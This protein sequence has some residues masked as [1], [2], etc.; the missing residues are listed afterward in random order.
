MLIH[1]WDAADPDEWRALLLDGHDFGQL[2]AAGRGRDVP[3]V[4]PTHFHYDGD[5]TV[6][7]HLARPN[8][9]WAAIEE[10][11][12]VL[13]T[14]IA[15]YAYVPGTWKADEGAD[16]RTGIPTSYYASVQLTA[17]ASVVDDP[18]G[19]R[20]ILRAS[21]AHFSPDGDHAPV[22][23]GAAWVDRRLPA[24]R[25]LRLAVTE[26]RAKLKYG[27]NMPARRRLDIAERLADRD[28]PNDAAARAHLL[29]RL[30]R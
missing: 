15:D 18:E 16:P 24:I 19:K 7:L 23:E 1:P 30:D 3:V 10:N 12:T 20:K 25:G 26:V 29:R 5:A 9:V 21:L 11:P 2:I 22:V 6:V 17:A 13:L 4:V 14:V 8:P 27:G 28:G